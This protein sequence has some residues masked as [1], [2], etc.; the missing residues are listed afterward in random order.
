MNRHTVPQPIRYTFLLIELAALFVA[1]R[2]AFETWL[3]SADPSGLWFYAAL[4]GLLLGQRLDTPFF[5]TPKD[6]VLYAIPALVAALQVPEMALSTTSRWG[7][8]AQALLVAWIAMVLVVSSLAVWLQGAKAE[9]GS[10]LGAAA[11][12]LSGSL[13]NPKAFFSVI[14]FLVLVAFPPKSIEGILILTAAWVVTVPFSLL[15]YLYA[16]VRRIR[17]SLAKGPETQS[18]AVVYTQHPGLLT[19]R[20]QRHDSLPPGRVFAYRD[21]ASGVRLAF[22]MS[23]AG[24]DTGVLM[25]A[26][27]LG[28]AEPGQDFP[29]LEL[30]GAMDV[31]LVSD[32][33]LSANQNSLAEDFRTNCI[34]FVAPETDISKLIVEV[35]A[36]RELAAGRLVRT[37]SGRQEIFYQLTN[38]LTKEEIIQQKNTCGFVAAH[39]RSVGI[40][41]EPEARFKAATW[42]PSPNAPVALVEQHDGQFERAR[43]G[44]FPGTDFGVRLQNIA[45]LVTHNTAILGIL[46]VGKSTLAMELVERVLDVGCKAIVLDLT[47]QY[48]SELADLLDPA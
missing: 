9:A 18:G 26:V 20:A 30:V 42:V 15:D 13:G 8:N 39:A 24:R 40:W 6:A 3:P 44:T 32:A 19:V 31:T 5:T 1:N 28:A 37:K 35:D 11:M 16:L 29:E 10:R 12:Q 2:F 4:F 46:G 7:D 41:I 34:G 27:D 17:W 45:H 25:R 43:I 33:E 21:S 48:A 36:E 14:L 47:D 22:I 23:H 38:G